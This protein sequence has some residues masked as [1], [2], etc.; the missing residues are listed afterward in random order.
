MDKAIRIHCCQTMV[1]YR[2]P[3]SFIIKETYPLPP[4]STVIGMIH[5]ICEFTEYHD[6]KISVQGTG[7]G[8]V[9]DMYTRYSFKSGTKYEAGRHNVK[10]PNS[11]G[12]FYGVFKGVANTELIC[13]IE[14]I[15]HIQPSENDYDTILRA[16]HNPPVYPSLG[17]YEDLLNIISIDEVELTEAKK[18]RSVHE[19]YAPA[20]DN[21]TSTI[22]HL[23]KEY[24]IDKKG[25][26]KWKEK[27]PI[28]HI[29]SNRILRNVIWDETYPVILV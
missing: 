29:T 1:N 26:R 22:Y 6:M 5:N 13:E 21:P 25:I 20:T 18:V 17:R 12:G 19:I 4:Y 23:G 7:K 27:L 24:V 3:A 16:L 11:Q 14:L 15:I 10:V 8:R 9:S 28:E 2:K